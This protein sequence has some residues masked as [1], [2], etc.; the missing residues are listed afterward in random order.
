MGD[1]QYYTSS[2]NIEYVIM[3]SKK[4]EEEMR[5]VGYEK[6]IYAIKLVLGQALSMA[7]KKEEAIEVY[8]TTINDN[9]MNINGKKRLHL[10][11]MGLYLDTND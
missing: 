4:M 8:L 11:L 10:R 3:E 5:R 9:I 7:E 1:M 2:G 6:G